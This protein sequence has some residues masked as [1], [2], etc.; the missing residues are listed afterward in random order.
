MNKKREEFEE[1]YADVVIE[2]KKA[3]K[4]YFDA[5]LSGR[6][7]I[8]V[9]GHQVPGERE[10]I[11]RQMQSEERFFE[12]LGFNFWGDFFRDE[13][14]FLKAMNPL[15]IKEMVRA[16]DNPVDEHAV[17]DWF[18]L[19][20]EGTCYGCGLRLNWRTNGKIIRPF[21]FEPSS[22]EG[23]FG[24][25][26]P[27]MCKFANGLPEEIKN[28]VVV[29]SGK[30]LVGNNLHMIFDEKKI[31]GDERYNNENSINHVSGKIKYMER[32]AQHHLLTGFL[33]DGGVD[34]YADEETVAAYRAEVD[35]RPDEIS[36]EGRTLRYVASIC[37][38]LWWW[39]LADYGISQQQNAEIVAT[40][41][42]PPKNDSVYYNFDYFVLPVKAG[43]Y[44]MVHY[45][46]NVDRDRIGI[47]SVVRRIGDL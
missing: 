30:L 27:K 24:D 14:T 7:V 34:V 22:V 46:N 16:I 26:V 9:R 11:L 38:E 18:N 28:V 21:I 25:F 6:V 47:Q 40:A 10:V 35:D 1:K 37:L 43:R 41:D 12:D 20:C 44:E 32:Y 3:Q 45:Q 31:W 29:P 13:Y 5:V 39:G 19:G 8:D 2:A 4:A 15:V 23:K 36:F 17:R 33:G 42:D